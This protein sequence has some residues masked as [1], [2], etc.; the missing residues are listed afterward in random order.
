M[1]ARPR[2]FY[3]ARTAPSRI[4]GATLAM[5]RHFLEHD[6]MDLF[7]ATSEAFEEPGVPQLTLKAPAWWRRIGRT[8]FWRAV[9][10]A[11]II[12]LAHRLPPDLLAAARQYRPD[13]IFTVADLTLSDNARLLA[14]RLGLPLIVNFQDWWPRG[15]FYYPQETPVQARGLGG[16]DP[17]RWPVGTFSVDHQFPAG[18]AFEGGGQLLQHTAIGAEGRSRV[19]QL[20]LPRLGSRAL[21]CGKPRHGG[22]GLAAADRIQHMAVGVRAE[23]LPHA[24]ACAESEGRLAVEAA[25]ATLQQRH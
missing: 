20:A 14:R 13:A 9:H 10:N 22:T 16:C 6:D 17:L 2:L 18:V 7:V 23:E 12:A 1:S 8:R 5:R 11:E 3:L 25:K 19:H 4:S 15:Q 21:R 24:L